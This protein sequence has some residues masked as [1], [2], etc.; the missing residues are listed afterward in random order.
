MKLKTISDDIAYRAVHEDY[1]PTRTELQTEYRLDDRQVLR[2]KKY[3]KE[4]ASKQYGLIWGYHPETNR[5]RI[6][7]KGESVLAKQILS[8]AA[9]QVANVTEGIVFQLDGAAKSG[10]ITERAH[11]R[12]ATTYGRVTDFANRVSG[13]IATS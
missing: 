8:Y 11:K 2:V 10:F 5:Y 4:N 1:R 9:S 6:V 3:V 12:G 7:P 13:L